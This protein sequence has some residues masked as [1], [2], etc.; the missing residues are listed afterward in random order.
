MPNDFAVY[1]KEDATMND[2]QSMIKELEK[3][4]PRPVS[5]EDDYLEAT[6]DWGT[7]TRDVNNLQ[8]RLNGVSHNK[9]E[10]IDVITAGAVPEVGQEAGTR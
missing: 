1:W 2:I 6:L 8:G 4:G 5:Q 3:I 7:S 9:V 10:S